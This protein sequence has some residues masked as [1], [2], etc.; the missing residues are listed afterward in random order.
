[1][2]FRQARKRQPSLRRTSTSTVL[3]LTTLMGTALFASCAMA[4]SFQTVSRVACPHGEFIV[5]ARPWGENEAGSSQVALRYRYRDVELTAI[6]Y[7]AYF[8]NLEPWLRKG[9]PPIYNLGLN[10]DTSGASKSSGY[11]R[12]DTLYLPPSRFSQA[13]V[14]SLFD[15]LGQQHAATLR[16]DFEK[17]EITSSAF[18]GLMTTRTTTGRTGVARLVHANAPI[19]SVYGSG[20]LLILIELGG[21]VLLHTN[22]TANNPAESIVW[23]HV[24]SEAGRRPVMRAE[25]R[26]HFYGEMRDTSLYL[27]EPEATTGRRLQD[28]FKVEWR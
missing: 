21:R 4:K 11:D 14:T 19:T 26:V 6:H 28:D 3:R 25:R 2:R 18:L 23:G 10:L 15:C 1:M 9:S 13:D 16:R 8:K 27:P 12:G 24:V 7:E 17:A 5:D 22:M 20:W